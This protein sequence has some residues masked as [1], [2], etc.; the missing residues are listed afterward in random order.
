[1][2]IHLDPQEEQMIEDAIHYFNDDSYS[3]HVAQMI[4]EKYLEQKR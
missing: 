4:I 3:A 1:M 2:E